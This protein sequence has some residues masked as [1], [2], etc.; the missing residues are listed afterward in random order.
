[1][2]NKSGLGFH[3]P[4][5]LND[6]QSLEDIRRQISRLAASQDMNEIDI[7]AIHEKWDKDQKRE[8]LEE[9]EVQDLTENILKDCNIIR[10]KNLKAKTL[11]KKT[12][13]VCGA[14][15]GSDLVNEPIMKKIKNR[16]QSANPGGSL[17]NISHQKFKSH[18]N[19]NMSNTGFPSTEFTTPQASSVMGNRLKKHRKKVPIVVK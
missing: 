19:M 1:M 2:N 7:E 11:T 15:L 9:V 18:T 12:G 4:T 14:R 10:D 8:G 16:I 3:V 17:R 5:K 13:V 6:V